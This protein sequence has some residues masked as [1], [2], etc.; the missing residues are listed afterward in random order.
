MRRPRQPWAILGLALCLSCGGDDGDDNPAP[1]ADANPDAFDTRA[2]LTNVVENVVLPQ[3]AAFATDAAALDTAV[4]AYCDA[5]GAGGEAAALTAAQDAWRDAMAGVA[6]VADD[7]DPG[8]VDRY[9]ASFDD[10]PR[11]Q[12]WTS[13][14]D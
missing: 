1:A 2:L 6:P 9:A 13:V 7:V 10:R 5:L 14:R 8:F 4:A 3:Y 12:G 11:K